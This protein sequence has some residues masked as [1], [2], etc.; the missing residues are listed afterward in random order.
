MSRRLSFAVLVLAAV[1]LVVPALARA[2][3]TGSAAA[4]EA[5]S[6]A[7]T[8][9]SQCV[10]TNGRLDVLFV[11]DQSGS[12]RFTDPLN[13]RVD[14]VDAALSGFARLAEASAGQSPISIRVLFE[15]F[16]GRV[17][18]DPDAPNATS[19][20]QTVTPQTLPGLLAQAAAF[21]SRNTGEDTDYALAFLAAR[22]LLAREAVAETEA[23]G[24]PP[25]K[26]IIWFTDGGYDITARTQVGPNALSATEPYAP[27]INLDSTA[28]AAAG[29]TAGRQFLCRPGG[30]L[31]GLQSDGVVKFTFGLTRFMSPYDEDF[32]E[33]VTTGKGGDLRCGST[34][35]SATG[36][37]QPITDDQCLFFQFGG[38]LD[39]GGCPAPTAQRA[40]NAFRTIPGLSGFL[41]RASTGGS[42]IDLVL[43]GPDHRSVTFDPGGSG[44]TNVAGAAV[45]EQWFSDRALELT[46]TFPRASSTWIGP[47][48]YVFVDPTETEPNA[49]PIADVQLIAGLAPRVSPQRVVR[50][51][52]TTLR[53]TFADPG[54]Q[55]VTSG[56]LLD[57]ARPTVTVTEPQQ[58]VNVPELVS[59]R[60]SGGTFTVPITLPADLTEP[61]VLLNVMVPFASA[62][63]AE[64][65]PLR[66]TFKLPVGLPPGFPTV[67]PESLQLA[68]IEG[69]G[70]STATLTVRA[71][72]NSGGCV[73]VSGARLVAPSGTKATT[74]TVSPGATSPTT[75]VS[76]APG[77]HTRLHVAFGATEAAVGTGD[78][79]V[80]VHLHSNLR[81]QTTT[82]TLVGSIELY[83][84]RNIAK[85][86]AILVLALV[87]GVLFPLALL[88]A[89]N[90]IGARFTPPQSL[91]ALGLD[92]TVLPAVRVDQVGRPH[93]PPQ[94]PRLPFDWVSKSAGA[95]PPRALTLDLTPAARPDAPALAV[96]LHGVTVRRPADLFVG[97]SGD[98]IVPGHLLLVGAVGHVRSSAGVAPAEVPLRLPGVW[99][100][101][102]ERITT[103]PN[104]LSAGTPTEVHGRL[105]LLLSL[106]P[107]LN[108]GQ[109]LADA[110]CRDLVSADWAGLLAQ[111]GAERHRSVWQRLTGAVHRP[112]RREYD[113]G[114]DGEWPTG[115][116][117][118]P[119]TDA[120]NGGAPGSPGGRDP[121]AG[122]D[123]QSGPGPDEDSDPP[124][125]GRR[126]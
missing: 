98:A 79:R 45:A 29:E 72:P 125:G 95:T 65:E 108:D 82:V 105:L 94:A 9:L 71:R 119:P 30:L 57:D 44:T 55:T 66:D 12:I 85:R 6:A 91:L 1:V 46:G 52:T 90:L 27:G 113:S 20:W 23:G 53:L 38:L 37:F 117:E 86:V 28:G 120:T 83:P 43:R 25:C 106:S 34:L 58:G 31:D 100:F 69:S 22:K 101:V 103:A 114:E 51:A 18:P 54:G 102:V 78:A 81:R 104:G 59:A 3:P 93:H 7:A 35:S 109:Q 26:A 5:P 14:G 21:R 19:L 68:S 77:A 2:Q 36:Q 87:L 42:D 89:L 33:A 40:L 88:F 118:G 39:G 13:Q 116:E 124:S 62:T 121:F 15:G 70:S 115:S 17:T 61:Y 64:I 67:T 41:L 107:A 80:V 11:I 112:R 32:L 56:P 8:T 111:A 4:S 92:V 73:W 76:L 84:P 110:A 60:G 47:W 122:S 96:Q 75:C 126:F 99:M 50:G 63:G 97:P 123:G 49:V 74:T 10:E 16:Y 24:A 48:S